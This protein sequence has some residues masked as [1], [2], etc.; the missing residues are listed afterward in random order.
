MIAWGL[1]GSGSRYHVEKDRHAL[2]DPELYLW[3]RNL[4]PVDEMKCKKCMRK[5][6]ELL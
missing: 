6:Q 1:S 2:C 5:S 4:V 3:D